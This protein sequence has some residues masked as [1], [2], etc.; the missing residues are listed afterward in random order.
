MR[1]CALRDERSSESAAVVTAR[2]IVPV[3]QINAHLGTDWPTD[4]FGLIQQ[5]L[6]L[7]LLRAACVEP[8]PLTQ[9]RNNR[10]G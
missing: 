3:G 5:G 1:L 8:I 2:G 9:G 4:L 7:D 10:Q 6:S